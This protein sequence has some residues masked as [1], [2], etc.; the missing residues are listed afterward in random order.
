MGTFVDSIEMPRIA[1]SDTSES[2]SQLRFQAVTYFCELVASA[3]LN[4]ATLKSEHERLHTIVEPLKNVL[5][6]CSQIKQKI[7]VEVIQIKNRLMELLVSDTLQKGEIESIEKTVI[8]KDHQD[9]LMWLIYWAKARHSF[10]CKNPIVAKNLFIQAFDS[11]KYRAGKLQQP[12][13]QNTLTVASKSGD[14]K[15]FKR[16]LR[17]AFFVGLSEANVDSKEEFE[18]VLNYE[19]HRR[20]ESGVITLS[21]LGD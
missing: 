12:L 6:E 21:R 2:K 13:V 14:M 17:W 3:T 8:E 16:V 15:L 19:F 20:S 7:P 1:Q 4:H 18:H 10:I 5:D 9:A 11:G